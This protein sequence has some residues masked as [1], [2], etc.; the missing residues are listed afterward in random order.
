MA[1]S[2][3]APALIQAQQQLLGLVYPTQLT[4]VST[5]SGLAPSRSAA[6]GGKEELSKEPQPTEGTQGSPRP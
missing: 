1:G 2:P 3:Q 4:P 6:A 5:R